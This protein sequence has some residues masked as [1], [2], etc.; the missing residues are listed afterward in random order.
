[1]DA[2]ELYA[3]ALQAANAGDSQTA[4]KLI[5]RS[6]EADP[7]FLEGWWALANIIDD[8]QQKRY[9]LDQVLKIDPNH[10]KARELVSKLAQ[11]PVSAEQSAASFQSIQSEHKPIQ[12]RS[13]HPPEASPSPEQEVQASTKTPKPS[14]NFWIGV[15]AALSVLVVGVALTYLIF[16]GV[17]NNPFIRSSTEYSD[18]VP[19]T[20]PAAWT[21][22]PT[23]TL[24]P[25]IE[26]TAEIL[27]GTSVSLL[28]PQYSDEVEN[29]LQLMQRGDLEGALEA[30]DKILLKDPDD[31]F[32]LAMRAHTLLRLIQNETSLS[33]YINTS[34]QAI[35]DADKAIAL[36]PNMNGDYYT[37][38]A[39]A[40]ENLSL[41]LGIRTDQDRYLNIALENLLI[42]N[43]LPHTD[44]TGYYDPSLFL[45]RLG[46]CS[47]AL[48]QILGLIAA[49]GENAAPVP[50]LHYRRAIAHFCLGEYE[51]GLEHINIAI[52][53]LPICNYRFIRVL[54][55]YHSGNVEQALSETNLILDDCPTLA[56]T[57]YYLRAL[58][59]TER[60]DYEKAY[61]DLFL[62]SLN[63]W[64][65]AGLKAYV[66]GLLALQE[67]NREQAIESLKLAEQTMGRSHGPFVE[68]I[69]ADL[70]AL[71]V[72]PV[73]ITPNPNPP[74][75]PIPSLPEDHPTP[76]PE[77]FVKYT[78]GTGSFTLEPG[79]TRYF[80]FFAPLGFE[81][82]HVSTLKAHLI[83]GDEGF[84]SNIELLIHNPA[85]AYWQSVEL[86]WGSNGFRSEGDYV[87]T[88][89][90]INIRLRNPSDES[91]ELD[92]FGI[93]ISVV[94]SM[95]STARYSYQDEG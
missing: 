82:D 7:G 16:A 51:P 91:V 95:G 84:P 38:R 90:D 12:H 75:T 86:V 21:A 46:K 43:A 80:H 14:R 66:E 28:Q 78:T 44:P 77:T 53:L 36:Y 88:S 20:L 57:R 56:G 11:S 58:I 13:Y 41:A 47:E 2:R 59:H 62:G 79:E 31:H 29:A 23:E 49:R 92:D 94:T 25:L 9:C 52:E 70:A 69:Q 6:V 1:M 22:T 73:V 55:H 54:I 15:I 64:Q 10:E 18:I 50:L 74:S 26:S 63:T 37:A 40:F 85:L 27:Q 35:A 71:G 17:I 42:G 67:G 4:R 33:N 34:L 81:Y 24:K 3:K 30:W 87:N 60:G 72:S 61:E 76:P 39:Y 32:S 5:V 93:S 65:Q 19:P 83:G 68:R 48:E 89:G 8:D 45:L